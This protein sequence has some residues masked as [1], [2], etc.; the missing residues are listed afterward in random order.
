MFTLSNFPLTSLFNFASRLFAAVEKGGGQPLFVTQGMSSSALSIAVRRNETDGVLAAI[1]D[2]F[3]HDAEDFGSTFKC[4]SSPLNA[5]L[6][7][8]GQLKLTLDSNCSILSVV[9]RGQVS[10]V[11]AMGKECF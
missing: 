2:T 5:A 7:P 4:L 8:L 11:G 1:A 3:R 10:F 9:G 6:H